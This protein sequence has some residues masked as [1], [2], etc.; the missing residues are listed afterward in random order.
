MSRDILKELHEGTST[1]DDIEQYY[2]AVMDSEHGGR[3]PELLGLTADEYTASAHGVYFDVLSR[4]R[5]EG[6]PT[7]CL[8]CGKPIEIANAHWLARDLGD[9]Q[10][11]VHMACAEKLLAPDGEAT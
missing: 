8:V 5:Y 1:L 11:L 2:D 4:W 7:N 6:W 10:G 3:V 9:R